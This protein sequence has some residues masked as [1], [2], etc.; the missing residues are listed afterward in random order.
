[1]AVSCLARIFKLV[2]DNKTEVASL[3][4]LIIC[5]SHHHLNT[6]KVATVLANTIGAQVKAPA[7]IDPAEL[8]KYDLIGF[9]SGIYFGKH[10]KTLL[11]LA[12]KLPQADKKKAFLFS[13]SGEEGK[14]QRLHKKLREKLQSNGYE[15]FGEF[16]CPGY[17]TSIFTKLVGGIQK[18][19]PNEE[20][21]KQ[22]QTFAENLKRTYNVLLLCGEPP[23]STSRS[24]LY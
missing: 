8:S 16:N 2:N 5:Y 12:A 6:Q 1:M 24:K 17:D 13:T 18:G 22:A 15:I 14:S 19:R 10:H 3:K 9:G 21:L 20:D 7:E 4:S 23:P 11:K